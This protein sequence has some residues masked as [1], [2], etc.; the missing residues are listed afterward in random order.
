MKS[1][2]MLSLLAIALSMVF[3]SGVMAQQ[4]PATPAPATAAPSPAPQSK[5][6]KFSGVIERVDSAT[7][8]VVVQE[9][10]EKMTFS[11]GD[12]TKITEGKK[13]MAF[14]DLKNGQWASVEYK[15]EGGKMAAE[16]ISFGAPKS[17]AKKEGTPSVKTTEK[18]LEKVPEKAPAPEKK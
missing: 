8:E 9:K 17:M 7:K 12:K 1:S 11:V 6:E 16:A 13:E 4:K 5:L 14:S 10:K 15:K 2:T 18:T 3:V